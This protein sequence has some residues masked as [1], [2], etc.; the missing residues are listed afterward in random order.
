[1]STLGKEVHSTVPR[2]MHGTPA[3]I[4]ITGD[5]LPISI[6]AGKANGRAVDSACQ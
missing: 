1:M 4:L 2:L 3:T 5:S 6:M